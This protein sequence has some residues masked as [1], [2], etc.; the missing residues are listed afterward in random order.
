M[1]E[2]FTYKNGFKS[3]SVRRHQRVGRL[4]FGTLMPNYGTHCKNCLKTKQKIQRKVKNS[5]LL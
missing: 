4:E 2:N 1:A 3:K 5:V